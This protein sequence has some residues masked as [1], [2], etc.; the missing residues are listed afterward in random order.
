VR[1]PRSFG[2]LCALLILEALGVAAGGVADTQFGPDAVTVSAGARGAQQR[3]RERKR[4]AH[5]VLIAAGDIADCDSPGVEA[6]A[7]SIRELAG[8]V[9][10]L[11]DTVYQTGSRQEFLQCYD[12]AWG[13]EKRRTRPAPGNHDYD[14]PGAK[15]YFDYFGA[16]AGD[17]DK[18][19]YSYDL[20][21]WHII[22]LNSNCGEVGG[23]AEN[24]PQGRWLRADLVAHQATC[25]LAYWHHP[26]FSSGREHGGDAAMRP[27]WNI[28]YDA[29]VDVTLSAHEHNYER[30]APQDPAGRLD[31]KRGI[32]AFVVGTGGASLYGLGRP[33]PTSETQNAD[34]FGVLVLTLRRAS[35]MWEFIPADARFAQGGQKPFRDAG[36]A[37]C[38]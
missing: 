38:H 9:A 11:G 5:P 25:T 26:L 18:G 14:T 24:S 37:D 6:T 34:T 8:T 3:D 12:P 1:H 27:F 17:R 21:S 31:R 4:R 33:E 36:S 30:F 23:C 19:Y 13:S 10:T 29:G 16:A 28:L 7:A 32:R 15:G 20:G 22:V 35:Y 2:I